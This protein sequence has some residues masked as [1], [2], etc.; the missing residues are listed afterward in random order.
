M[1][2]RGKPHGE[3]VPAAY[4]A[5]ILGLDVR[6]VRGWVQSGNVPGKR[7]PGIK[8]RARWYVLRSAFEAL[9]DRPANP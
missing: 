5:R 2:P 8:G 4:V 6:T 9:R 3:L 7:L 1:S